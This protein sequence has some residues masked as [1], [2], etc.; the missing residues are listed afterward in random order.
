MKKA[1]D[2]LILK[3]MPLGD[4]DKLLT[5]LTAKEGKITMTA[6]GARSARSKVTSVCRLFTYANIEYYEKNDRRWLSGG[7]VNDSFFGLNSDIEGFSLAAYIIQIADDITG[8][9]VPADDVLRMTLNSLYCIEKKL[10]PLWQ[11]KA[12]YE[13]FSVRISG[14]ELDLSFCERCGKGDC[15]GYWLDV[16]NGCIICE[17]CM[18]KRSGGA[19][20]PEYDEYSA[21][22]IFLPM[23]PSATASAAYVLSADISRIFAFSIKDERSIEHFCRAA[24]TYLLNHLERNFDTLDFYKSV[25]EDI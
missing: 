11:I 15:I 17:D 24:E 13:F 18:R 16:M 12:V 25:K 21:R 5:V 6:K 4:N 23:D 14:M 8:E 20:M 9:G 3:E 22:N 2:G 19:P 1:V 10:K 7:S